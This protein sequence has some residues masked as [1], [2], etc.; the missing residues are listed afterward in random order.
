MIYDV[1]LPLIIILSIFG[2]IVIL[3]RKIPDISLEA[4]TKKDWFSEQ[5]KKQHR[6]TVLFCK[7]LSILE[8]TLR[9]LR[10]HILKLDA[11]IFSLIQYLREKSAKKLDELNKLSY[12]SFSPSIEKKINKPKLEVKLQPVSNVKLPDIKKMVIPAEP[13]QT[14]PAT[15]VASQ[16]KTSKILEYPNK[17]SIKFQFK[18][19]ERKLLHIIASNPKNAENYK[20]LGMLYYNYNNFLDAEAAFSEYLK[21][22]PA[23]NEIKEMNKRLVL[24]NQKKNMVLGEV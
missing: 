14:E 23:D 18:V 7:V 20:K 1:S 10:I 9:Q 21:L 22:N 13:V 19:E 4:E 15:K 17:I 3:A 11:K 2:I 5:A 24:K 6:T 16:S 8:K 12:K